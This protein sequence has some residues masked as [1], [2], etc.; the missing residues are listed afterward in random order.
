MAMALPAF[1]QARKAA[2]ASR[3]HARHGAHA[4]AVHGRT[5]RRPGAGKRHR[6]GHGAVKSLPAARMAPRGAA[7]ATGASC[8]DASAP[9]SA[10]QGPSACADG[11]EPA[12]ADGSSAPPAGGGEA[13]AACPTSTQNDTPAAEIACEDAAG[14]PCDTVEEDAAI[15]CQEV[16]PASP[17]E[18]PGFICEG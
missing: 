3:S 18:G 6:A 16:P 1:A 13:A 11:G 10:G 12:C 7:G 17:G 14:Q 9:L 4:C 2:C 15:T 5:A 8:E